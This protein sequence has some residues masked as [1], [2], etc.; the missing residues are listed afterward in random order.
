MGRGW[1]GS[2][3][4]ARN[5]LG[6]LINP[7]IVRMEGFLGLNGWELNTAIDDAEQT[8]L[9]LAAGRLSRDEFV[10][11]VKNASKPC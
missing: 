2:H 9:A 3:P 7:V 5:G 8:M 11:W 10:Q 1:I 4:I 6:R